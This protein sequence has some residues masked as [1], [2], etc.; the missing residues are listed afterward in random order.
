MTPYIF[1]FMFILQSNQGTPEM[2]NRF[3]ILS[4]G[5]QKGINQEAWFVTKSKL[6]TLPEYNPLLGNPPLS[7]DRAIM[8]AYQHI[9]Q[10]YPAETFTLKNITLFRFADKMFPFPS[11]IRND[12]VYL[13]SFQ[14]HT[15]GFV[16]MVP[17]LLSGEIV[18]SDLEKQQQWGPS[19]VWD[20]VINSSAFGRVEKPV[21]I[22]IFRSWEKSLS[23]QYTVDEKSQVGNLDKM[24]DL[25]IILFDLNFD[26]FADIWASGCW[27]GQCRIRASE[28]W[29]FN[30]KN[31]TYMYNMQLSELKNLQ[32]DIEKKLL[33]DGVWNCGCS[34]NCFYHNVYS[35]DKNNLIKIMRREQ[36]CY[37]DGILYNKYNV[38]NGKLI[39]TETIK[40]KPSPEEYLRRQRGDLVFFTQNEVKN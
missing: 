22:Q 18:F 28:V 31:Q 3:L 8:L 4:S 25:D 6:M 24:F 34:G 5:D 33:E 30:P 29:L 9:L 40:G 7:C 26:G 21:H 15:D 38:V 12:W 11:P 13:V 17:V 39:I 35:W 1:L 14:Y 23:Y 19:I 10:R 20:E 32:V 27:N 37:Q 36:N 2:N 16:Q